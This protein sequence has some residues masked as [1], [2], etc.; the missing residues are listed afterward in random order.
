MQLLNR[1]F[2]I[3]VDEGGNVLIVSETGKQH[4]ALLREEAR[5]LWQMLDTLFNPDN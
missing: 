3:T 4:M 2:T 5:M 1:F